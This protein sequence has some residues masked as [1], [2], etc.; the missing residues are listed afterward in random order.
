MGKGIEEKE[1][2]EGKIK[3]KVQF[4]LLHLILLWPLTGGVLLYALLCFWRW[5]ASKRALLHSG[6]VRCCACILACQKICFCW[7]IFIQ[8]TIFAAENPPFWRN[9]WA[10]LKFWAP[11][12]FSVR[13]LLCVC[14]KTFCP[15]SLFNLQ[16]VCFCPFQIY[17]VWVYLKQ[18]VG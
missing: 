1:R 3:S 16:C 7:K 8:N 10:K 9:V 4:P 12:V 14:Q 2:R 11:V 13:S 5:C 17:T 6:G 18:S 15:P